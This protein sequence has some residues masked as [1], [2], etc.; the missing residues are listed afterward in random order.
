M[1]D[2]DLQ[3]FVSPDG[4][5][6]YLEDPLFSIS[7]GNFGMPPV[8]YQ[9]RRGYQ[10]DG[11]TVV[12]YTLNN[13]SILLTLH[14]ATPATRPLYWEKRAELI[15]FFRPNRGG[16]FTFTIRQAG[17]NK[18]SLYVYPAPGFTF[19]PTAPNDAVN[20]IEEGLT[21]V[22]YDPVWFD[23]ATAAVVFAG[24]AA[25]QLVFP[26]TF[27]I[28]FSPDGTVYSASITY[29][30]N[31]K[32]YPI[33]T[34]TGPY[35]SAIIRNATT[36]VSIVLNIPIS[37]GVQRIV[38]TTPGAQSVTDASGVDHFDDL[39]PETNLV[40][41]NIR[42]EGLPPEGVTGGINVIEVTFTGGVL[43]QSDVDLSYS[44][45]YVGI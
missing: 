31:Y 10:Q 15:D 7:Y 11:S 5:T 3:S 39:A 32:S 8:D 27:P 9:T 14:R 30:G 40:D 29:E 18:R 41:F 35:N 6:L 26:I 23:P 2:S 45:K 34:L 22:A 28:T 44:A 20:E 42:P 33:I 17:G 43:G 19:P 21:F 12:D 25:S 13:R 24:T 16:A 37:A 36:G 38:D 1:A 4:Q